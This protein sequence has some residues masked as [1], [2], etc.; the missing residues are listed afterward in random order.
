MKGS[1]I[2]GTVVCTQGFVLATHS[3]T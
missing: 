1:F 3:I 2:A